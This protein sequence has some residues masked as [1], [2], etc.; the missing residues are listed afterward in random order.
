MPKSDKVTDAD[1]LFSIRTVSV[2]DPDGAAD[3]PL[4]ELEVRELPFLE[5]LR[6]QGRVGNL[7][8]ALA[9]AAAGDEAGERV[10]A[11]EAALSRHADE[12]LTFVAATC[13]RPAEW[14]GRLAQSDGQR[15]A[16]MA[17]VLN[18]SFFLR[19]L[20]LI[21]EARASQTSFTRSSAPDTG[22]V[23]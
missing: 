14:V 8:A 1:I 2:R 17:W 3:A 15:L 4:V 12:W 20:R 6:L 16:N 7:I 13:G 9:T 18:S 5:A 10:G 22:A 21:M 23:H 11:A 19:S